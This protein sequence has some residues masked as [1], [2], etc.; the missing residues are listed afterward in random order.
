M[1]LSHCTGEWYLWSIQ[2]DWRGLL[3]PSTTVHRC[4]E[5]L[6]EDTRDGGLAACHLSSNG[7]LT[8]ALGSESKDYFLRRRGHCLSIIADWYSM[9]LCRST[10]NELISVMTIARFWNGIYWWV[11]QRIA[12]FVIHRFNRAETS[13]HKHYIIRLQNDA[14]S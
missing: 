11:D 8:D 13:T 6:V 2:S 4:R 12:H 3:G 9:L 14:F 7:L 5:V 10:K 1:S